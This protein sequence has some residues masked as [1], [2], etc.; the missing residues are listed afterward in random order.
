VTT[1]HRQAKAGRRLP[2]RRK[3]AQ[4]KL[5]CLSVMKPAEP[6]LP[7]ETSL[8]QIGD[9]INA[10][11]TARVQSYF[12]SREE[13]NLSR[14]L[15][16]L[17]EQAI[18]DYEH[19]AVLELVQN[20]HDAQA[21]GARDGR[22]LI[23][24]DHED[25]HHGS[26]LVANTGRP[27]TASNFDAICDV[28]QSDKRADEGIGN[29]G[30]G[31]KSTLQ[32]CRVPEIYSVSDAGDGQRFDGYCFRF[33]DDR[34][35]LALVDNDA[36][37]A[38]ELAR[39]VFHLCLP[40]AIQAVPESVQRLASDGYVTVIRLQ[41]KSEAA[42]KEAVEE[43]LALEDRPPTML[44]LRR[45]STLVVEERVS[46]T[47]TQR[48]HQR[49]EQHVAE[50]DPASIVTE[51]NLGEAGRFLVAERLV[52]GA[53][54]RA[55]IAESIEADRVSEGWK[56]WQGEARVGVAVPIDGVLTEGRLYTF[57]PMGDHAVAPLP[58]HVNAPFFARLARVDFEESV[59]LNDFLLDEVAALSATL[60]LGAAS[61]N[62]NLP[63]TA[64]ADLLSWSEPAHLRLIRAFEQQGQPLESA[65]VVPSRW[66]VGSWTTL[67]ATRYWD[68][69]SKK[70]LT[71]K[72]LSRAA[73]AKLLHESID[74]VRLERLSNI[75]GLLTGQALDPTGEEIA[76]WAEA[77]A[78][79]GAKRAF[80]PR[81]WEGF[82]DELATVTVDPRCLRGR[83]IL[84]DDDAKLQ[85]CAG[86]NAGPT[87]PTP[88]FSPKAEGG[89]AGNGDVDLRIPS[90]LKRQ[91]VFVNQQIRWTQRTGQTII[92]RPGRRM[93]DQE[94]AGLVNEYRA[95]ELFGVLGR[96]LRNKPSPARCLDALRWVYRFVRSREEPPW[97]EIAAV[98]FQ[99]PTA[100][101][102]W[103]PAQA[104]LFSRR[105][106]G[107]ED[108]VL[109]QFLAGS[110][111]LSDELSEVRG[112][113][114]C[115]PEDWPFDA[116]D[117]QF[118]RNFLERLGVR[119]GLWP[120]V[121]PR[122]II[123]REGRWFE[124][125]SAHTSVSLPA[126]TRTMWKQ[127]LT[128]RAPAG[129]RPYTRYRSD[130]PQYILP[131]QS[132]HAFFDDAARRLYAQLI[133]FGLDRWDQSMLKVAFRRWNDSS[134]RFSWPTPAFSFLE[135]ADWLPMAR[136]GERSNWYFVRPFEAWSNALGE[137]AAPIFAPLV[138][139]GIRRL[140]EIR[141][142][143]RE[144]LDS[145]GVQFWDSADTAPGRVRLLGQLLQEDAVPETGFAAF[146]KAY[147]EAWNDVVQH[148]T[149][150]PFDGH[151]NQSLVVTRKS[152]LGLIEGR[153]AGE[154]TEQLYVQD[155]EAT[156]ALRLL[157]Q[158]GA[159]VLRLR[160]G[161][162][163]QVAEILAA[164][165]GD[166][167]RRVSQTAVAVRVDG[168]SFEPSD[169]G[170]ALIT[171]ERLWLIE[172]VG[173]LTELRS[174]QFRHLGHEAI[175]RTG[176]TLRR[177][178]IVLAEHVEILVDQQPVQGANRVLAL[179]DPAHPTI[180]IERS[181]LK[182]A[183]SMLQ[184]AAPAI[185]EL[186]GHPDIADSIR[187]S[188]ID[189]HRLGWSDERPPPLSVLAE[190]IGE[191][192]ERLREITSETKQPLLE[193]GRVLVPLLAVLDLEAAHD[194]WEGLE[195]FIDDAAI[196]TWIEGRIG[197]RV[198]AL[199]LLAAC[200]QEDLNTARSALGVSL[201]DLNAA[202]NHLGE[203][204]EPLR[205][206][207]GIEHAFRYFLLAHRGSIL[208]SLRTA[209]APAYAT[210]DS[211]DEYVARRE[212]SSLTADPSWVDEFYDID[213]ETIR[214][215]VNEWLTDVGASP[216]DSELPA[217]PPLDD[218]RRSNRARL[219]EL[220]ATADALVQAWETR[221]ERSLSGL[222]GEPD[223]VVEAA[224]QAGQLD[225]ES[226][227][228]ERALAWFDAVGRWPVGMPRTLEP[229]ALGLAIE[230]V[231]AAALKRDEETKRRH[232]ETRQIAIDGT[233]VSAEP[234]NYATI[235]DTIR[236]GILP[237]LLAT[238][239]KLT[240]LGLLAPAHGREGSRGGHSVT[241][242]RRPHLSDVQAAAVGLAGEVVAL[243][244]LRSQYDDV[245]DA[246]WRSGYRNLLLG[247][248]EGDD[249]LGF[250]FEVVSRRHRLF[251]EVK[252]TTG[253]TCQ[254][255]LTK[256]EITAAQGIRRG[257]AYFVLYVT[258]VLSS[259]ERAIYLLPNPFGTAGIGRYRTVGSG[260]RL[261]FVLG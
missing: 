207:E 195:T 250:D 198:D 239:P 167:V 216:I 217:W 179:P 136:A 189:L 61:N 83:R 191:P 101:G 81:W 244:W 73:S 213:D 74:G 182:D 128:E 196:V 2:I 1:R 199:Q 45:I 177:I 7:F 193:L 107:M 168:Q 104:G 152:H 211:L 95:T 255:D 212:L 17:I 225:F 122:S 219:H 184:A 163:E 139:H 174:G 176:E 215:R 28:A 145:L 161:I 53:A 131:G 253:D 186:I 150:D 37:R 93:L 72:V 220:A 91:I 146:K 156:Q 86:S 147:E 188:L 126:D 14:S 159:P 234:Q 231:D 69:E 229:F 242:A 116:D 197:H 108:E 183:A 4:E 162:G 6:F 138:P 30:I 261:Q 46:G 8:N 71:G 54:F 171:Q 226:L 249:A 143:A 214:M 243:E 129:L 224:S 16:N 87:G 5:R 187:V 109:D 90:T 205:N 115:A 25:S 260:L 257:D 21:K 118:L 32:L 68:D 181:D 77:V 51:V 97:S 82:Y 55:S 79:V 99:V 151:R 236:A 256:A 44:F 70:V 154:E 137:E 67:G 209:F 49:V 221:A 23:R 50:L 29:K 52:D 185:A 238:P 80:D 157:E 113:L 252:A 241:A 35:V 96:A 36:G 75:M 59:P 20:A 120:E 19:R 228:E 112:R 180:V 102:G 201:V 246:S 42:R 15:K 248:D 110:A 92:R 203:P 103:I 223:I 41:L 130:G 164:H 60:V 98:G 170:E 40:V 192:E 33:V 38:A 111:G 26:L 65:T 240:E 134:D 48:V 194:L 62:V 88:F 169:Q 58:G 125:L 233:K 190:V 57:L 227:S 66:P 11:T 114:L 31:F 165:L 222:P 149:S 258:N 127:S 13:W 135:Q 202:I 158:R 34:D 247:G 76:D 27:F 64:V 3:V 251:F 153:G 178:R 85:R 39:D 141:P 9:V 166:R 172:L 12:D 200:R 18:H 133:V 24:L 218:L 121:V 160:R 235:V 43:V 142:R 132:E 148:A 245:T 84:I 230:D 175:R 105:W 63:A 100:R 123:A 206:P 10:K 259:D 22:I 140:I 78:A 232:D 89:T 47:T 94:T 117:H 208:A 173:A 144:R 119:S 124:D 210:F 237:S 254:F 56:D 204:F 155:V 106:G